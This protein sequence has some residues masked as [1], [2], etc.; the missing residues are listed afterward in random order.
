MK[1]GFLQ[2]AEGNFSAMR[3]MCFEVCTAA[4]FIAVYSAIKDNATIELIGMVTTML[5]IAIGG[6]AVQKASE[7]KNGTGTPNQP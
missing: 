3:L 5:G 7:V 6:K 4:C 1:I 2:E